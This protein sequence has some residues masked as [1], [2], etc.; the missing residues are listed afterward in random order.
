MHCLPGPPGKSQSCPLQEDCTFSRTR[1][2]SQLGPI[3]PSG[4]EPVYI[5]P[6]PSSRGL[7]LLKETPEH[8]LQENWP[9]LVSAEE[10]ARLGI[11]HLAHGVLQVWV[12]LD[13]QENEGVGMEQH[14]LTA[15]SQVPQIHPQQQPHFPLLEQEY[16]ASSINTG[17]PSSTIHH[18]DPSL[19]C[20]TS[21][22]HLLGK[23]GGFDLHKCSS[24][25]LQV[26]A[27]VV[28]GD[29]ARPWNE[30]DKNC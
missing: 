18:T 25:S 8:A 21:P 3:L 2:P 17:A 26:T 19:G 14:Q 7:F 5:S 12:D 29:T 4:E 11:A 9:Y 6:R 28:E 10:W 30:P 22:T 24:H 27:V 16:G 1:P 13:L 20:P 23:L 15:L